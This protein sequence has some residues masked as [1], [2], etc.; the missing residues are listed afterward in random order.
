[1][2]AALQTITAAV[3]GVIA[4]LAVTFAVRTLFEQ[5]RAVDVM[6][7]TIQVPVWSSV[8]IFAVVVATVSFVGLWRLKWKIIPVVAASAVAGFVV[9]GLIKG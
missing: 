4:H 5:V 3:V 9:K 6:G 2:G 1:M 8:N 7:G